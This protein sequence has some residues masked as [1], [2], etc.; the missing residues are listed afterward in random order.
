MTIPTLRL[1]I[2]DD[3]FH[4]VALK[5]YDELTVRDYLRI[6]EE[7]PPGETDQQRIAGAFGVP[8]RFTMIMR[9]HEAAQVMTHYLEWIRKSAEQWGAVRGILEKLDNWEDPAAPWTRE[10]AQEL[11]RLEGLDRKTITVGD[12]VFVVPER[13]EH[14]TVWGQWLSLTD[15]VKAHTGPDAALYPK[16][17]ALLCLEEGERYPSQGKE[18]DDHAFEARFVQWVTDRIQLFH[19]ARMVDAMAVCAFFLSSSAQ[20][21]AIMT[22][23]TSNCPSWMK[24]WTGQMQR[25]SATDGA[26]APS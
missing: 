22:A 12:R 9:A 13:V 10:D 17:L 11:M 5:D 3:D 25:P 4:E 8:R 24:H 16:V 20:F 21:S 7:G 26:N 23:S 14:E 2:A 18:E 15:T 1:V 19:E 6:T